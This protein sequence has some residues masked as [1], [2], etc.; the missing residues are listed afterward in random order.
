MVTPQFCFGWIESSHQADV[1]HVLCKSGK[2]G[3][4]PGWWKLSG[5]YSYKEA[6]LKIEIHVICHMNLDVLAAY[7]ECVC[8]KSLC[9]VAEQQMH[10]PFPGAGGAVCLWRL[11]S[12]DSVQVRPLCRYNVHLHLELS[13]T[14]ANRPLAWWS[15]CKNS[16]THLQADTLR[17]F[18]PSDVIKSQLGCC[19]YFLSLVVHSPALCPQSI[20]TTRF[21]WIIKKSLCPAGIHYFCFNIFLHRIRSPVIFLFNIKQCFLAL[22]NNP[23]EG[24]TWKSCSETWINLI[25]GTFSNF[26]LHAIWFKAL[27]WSAERTL[28]HASYLKAPA[29]PKVYTMKTIVL[30]QILISVLKCWNVLWQSN[31]QMASVFFEHYCFLLSAWEINKA[32]SKIL[33]LFVCGWSIC[34]HYQHLWQTTN[35]YLEFALLSQFWLENN[36]GLSEPLKLVDRKEECRVLLLQASFS[37]CHSSLP[38]SLSSFKERLVSAM[39]DPGWA[40]EDVQQGI[41]AHSIGTLMLNWSLYDC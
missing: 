17:G 29:S 38:V 3:Y 5:D 22:M 25:S 28:S 27:E 13:C 30:L 14:P 9:I 39:K 20:S 4:G 34:L 10:V 41:E 23:F 37:F 24:L 21:H 26:P 16:H 11:W 2:T 1:I 31:T 6:R 36:F 12:T 19:P 15:A 8:L 35:H 7:C 18:N 32:S 33:T 40:G